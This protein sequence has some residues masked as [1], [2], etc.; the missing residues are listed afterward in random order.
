MKVEAQIP[1]SN[2]CKTTQWDPEAILGFT[3]L[4]RGSFTCVGYAPSMHR[5]CRNP[6][7]QNER[8]LVYGMLDLLDL[9][10][11]NSGKVATQL[12]KVACRSLCWRHGDQANDVVEKWEASIAAYKAREN[13]KQ[14]KLR[15]KKSQPASSS[16]YTRKTDEHVEAC[17]ECFR[18]KV[19]EGLEQ[20]R[21]RAQQDQERKKMEEEQ[22]KEK[23]QQEQRDKEAR[24]RRQQE[25]QNRRK[26]EQQEREQR[27]REQKEQR[28]REQREQ[29]E[30]REIG[31][32]LV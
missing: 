28:E 5:R 2:A 25:A 17:G 29:R 31:R 13:T 14:S 7:G 11:T 26:R 20:G 23:R 10:S 24:E 15:T 12:K 8:D 19:R 3:N 4:D 30:Q 27:E 6:I 1:F 21:K 18:L 16:S 9:R 22:E 32:A